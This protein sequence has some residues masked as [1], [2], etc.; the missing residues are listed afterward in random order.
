M[1]RLVLALVIMC[2]GAATWARADEWT[3]TYTTSGKPELR[4]E[5]SDAN[6]HVDTW[7]Q[8][9][10]EARVIAEHYKI[11]S[12]ELKIYEHQSGDSV[13]IEVRFPVTFGFGIHI[14]HRVDIE[15]HMPRE[16]R[17]YLHAGDGAIRLANLKGT[18]ELQTGDG[19]QTID[20]VDGSLR[21]R[22]GDGHISAS[23]RFDQLEVGT[24]DGRVQVRALPASTL[25]SSWNLHAGDGSIT[26]SLP[27]NLAA[28]VDLHTSDGRITVDLPLA[29]QGR[30]GEKNIHGKLNGGG[31]LISVHTGDGSIRIEK[32]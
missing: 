6:I 16:G 11:N 15:V 19:S 10:I 8:S 27:D 7:D 4:V 18:M 5:T 20:G 25:A 23:G 3:K 9:T 24:G 13:E 12:R 2:F 14:S 30:L 1:K 31:N 17:V 22:A 28:D 32:S 29:V 21:A 26:L